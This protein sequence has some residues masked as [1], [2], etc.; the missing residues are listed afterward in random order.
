MLQVIAGYDPEDATSTDTPVPDYAA[1]L[2]ARTGSLRIG[3]ARAHF[4][5][6]LDPEVQA[7]MDAAL[8]VLERLTATQQTIEI[9]AP[10]DVALVVTRLEA[11][12]YHRE[13]VTKT[14]E[15]YQPNTLQRIRSCAD[16]SA[17]DYANA[18]RQLDQA[19]RSISNVFST[20]DLVVTPTTP[21]PPLTI[22]D[23]LADL[24]QLRAKELPSTTNVRPFNF[25]GLPAVSVPCGFTRKGLPIGLQIAGPAWGEAAVL[26][27]AH[28]YEQATD[29][30]K[31]KPTPS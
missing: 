3:V 7:A 24:D 18:R 31:R 11:Y 12:A 28:A 20:V 6:G 14:P 21:A 13:L 15:L 22:S 25:S 29:W 30:H 16:I 17:A 10:N 1:G 5:D 19:R 27:L 8:A 4:F 9:P 26:Q 23:L 2:D